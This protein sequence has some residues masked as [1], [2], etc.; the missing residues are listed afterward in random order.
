MFLHLPH[1]YEIMTDNEFRKAVKDGIPDDL[2]TVKPFDT[3]VNHAP[4]RKNILSLE[5]KK[6]AIRNALRY[7]PK[8][9]HAVLAPEFAD[10]LVKFGRIYMYRFRPAYKIFARDIQA[11]P[12]R[13]KQAAAIM[14]ML[15]NNLDDAVAQHPHE[16]IA[17]VGT[18]RYSRTGPST[19]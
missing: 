10:E 11:Y 9:H 15:S 5:E 2:P 4:G 17:M 16:L 1:K 3:E 18:A 7:F 14:L 12:H 19:S 6:L 13:S 8:K